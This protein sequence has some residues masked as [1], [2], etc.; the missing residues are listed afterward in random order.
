MTRFSRSSVVALAALAMLVLLAGCGG[1]PSDPTTTLAGTE[2][3]TVEMTGDSSA[4]YVVSA[5]LVADPFENVTV[6]YA[7]GT[8]RTVA[9]PEPPSAVTYG[10]ESG[11]TAVEPGGEVVGGAYFEGVANFSV[12]D[13]DVPPTGNAV[14]TVRQQ[15]ADGETPAPL[16]AWGVIRCDGH[17]SQVSL[18]V[19]ESGVEGF[20]FGCES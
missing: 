16:V 5:D 15:G 3:F 7:N 18:R 20:G 10:P 13:H 8:T 2:T 4:T 17:V 1:A 14:V 6:T 12:T 9:P 19:G 11:A